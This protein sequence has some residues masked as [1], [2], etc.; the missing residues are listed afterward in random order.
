MECEFV[1]VALHGTQSRQLF[2]AVGP[3]EDL[4]QKV[5][6]ALVVLLLVVANIPWAPSHPARER[7][8]CTPQLR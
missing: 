4:Q 7:V 5:E 8:S 2:E 3:V 6:A 1:H